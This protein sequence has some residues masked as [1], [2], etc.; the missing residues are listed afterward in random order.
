M[1]RRLSARVS[2]PIVGGRLVL[3]DVS[4]ADE[5]APGS[6]R[7]SPS[8][9]EDRRVWIPTYRTL[10]MHGIHPL[11]CPYPTSTDHGSSRARPRDG[12]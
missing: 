3:H 10:I 4:A 11:T 7:S 6:P 2:G 5:H 9:S 1:S 12:S 8:T